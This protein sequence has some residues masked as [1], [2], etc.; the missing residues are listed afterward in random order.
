MAI[1]IA[2]NK[3]EPPMWS[4]NSKGRIWVLDRPV[5]MGILNATPDSFHAGSRAAT[6]E[7]VLALAERMVAEGA[8]ILDI[9]GESTR[10]GSRRIDASEELDRVIPAIEAVRKADP[11]I[12]ISVD[13]YHAGVA[14]SAVVAGADIVNDISAGDLDSQMVATV[15]RLN[16]P[17]IAMHMRGDPATMQDDP[18]YGNV[19]TE[20]LD[21]FIAKRTECLAAGIHD[22]ILDPGFGF[23]KTVRHNFSLLASLD[24]FRILGLPILAGLSRKSM[25]TRT[26]GINA[27]DALNGTTALNMVALMNGA[28]ILRVHD[29]KEAVEAVRLYGEMQGG[30]SI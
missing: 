1:F 10:P 20:V 7:Q 27:A 4:M 29:V 6:E 30:K 24:R 15:A 19:V 9:G 3:Q 26:L 28:S 8:T 14:E 13:T 12:L 22:L 16:V 2:K 25:I 5:V 18:Q 11:G 23:G 17:Y 21:F